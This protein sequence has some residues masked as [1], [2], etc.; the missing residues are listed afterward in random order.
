MTDWLLG[1]GLQ[2]SALGGKRLPVIILRRNRSFRNGHSRLAG[3]RTRAGYV[4]ALTLATT[5]ETTNGRF[6]AMRSGRKSITSM[7]LASAA[8][9]LKWVAR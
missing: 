3:K 4:T 8:H 7:A 2:N 9:C 1:S 5:C 6:S